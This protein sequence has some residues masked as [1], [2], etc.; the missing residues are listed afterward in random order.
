MKNTKSGSFEKLSSSKSSRLRRA[1]AALDAYLGKARIE[2]VQATS[3]ASASIC[4]VNGIDVLVSYSTP[5]A[6][7]HQDGS[8]V[9]VTRGFYSRTTTRSQDEFARECVYLG[10]PEFREA[11]REVLK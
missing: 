5:V 2:R 10:E 3:Q 6:Y 4:L 9:A 8:C 7:R 1:E 11:L